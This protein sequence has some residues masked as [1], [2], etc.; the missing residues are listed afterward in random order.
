MARLVFTAH[1]AAI[2]PRDEMAYDGATLGEA[3]H[4][5]FRDHPALQR[6][7]LDDQGRVRRHIAIFLDGRLRARE[8][9]ARFAGDARERNLCAAGAVGR[10]RG[11]RLS[12][13]AATGRGPRL[14]FLD[15]E[16]DRRGLVVEA[17][18]RSRVAA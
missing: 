17:H 12:R 11:R 9:R 7:I 1:L 16:L 10:A 6:Y 14:D 2:V 18:R 15:R 4:A 3:L 13:V 5:A 8:E